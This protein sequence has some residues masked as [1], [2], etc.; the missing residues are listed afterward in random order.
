MHIVYKQIIEGYRRWLDVMGYAESQVYGLPRLVTEYLEWLEKQGMRTIGSINQETANT[1]M[2]YFKTRP[3]KR[4]SGSL[5]ISHINKQM[6]AIMK[7]NQY[8]KA[9]G[10]RPDDYREQIKL[11]EI[12]EKV[13]KDRMILSKEEIKQLYDVTDYSVIGMRDKVMLG[14]YYGCGL[15]KREG[16]LLSV[17]DVLFDRKLIYVRAPKN[18]YERYVPVTEKILQDLERY[19]YSARPMLLGDKITER[20]FVSERGNPMHGASMIARLNSIKKKAGNERSFGLHALRHSIATHL[21]QAGM[22]LEDIALFLGH[23]S[24]DSTQVYTRIVNEIDH[25]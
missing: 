10:K 18:G 24:I 19:I 12:K 11:Q 21:L 13:K 20:L 17:D 1:F 7:L 9:T 8:L 4:T 22:A 25:K 14:I 5:S 15:R 2:D 23:R 6:Y 16:L 3:N